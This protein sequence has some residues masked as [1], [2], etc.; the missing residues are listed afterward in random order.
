MRGF[1]ADG[2]AL[3][4]TSLEIARLTRYKAQF[5]ARLGPE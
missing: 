4:G 2:E 1:P 3:L 5:D